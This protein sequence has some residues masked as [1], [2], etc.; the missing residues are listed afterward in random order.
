MRSAIL[1]TLALAS[2]QDSPAQN[3]TAAEATDAANGF[4]AEHLPQVPLHRL[5]IE[6][7]EAGDHWRVSYTAPPD[8][9]GGP[10]VVQVDKRNGGILNS[11]MDQ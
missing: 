8:S 5:T 3:L 1:L 10:I 2:C 4:L 6:A 9:T 7:R 11:M